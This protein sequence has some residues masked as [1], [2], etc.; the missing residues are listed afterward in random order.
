MIANDIYRI[1]ESDLQSLI[2]NAVPEG[3]TI[4]YKQQLQINLDSEKKE[5]LAD[6]SSFA[7]ASGGDLIIG[8][9]EE[10]GN[11]KELLGIEIDDERLRKIDGVIREGINPK[12]AIYSYPT[13]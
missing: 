6:V 2:V 9:S 3:K 5:F 8:I 11:P 13:D 4:E 12:A 1:T 7:N 10:E